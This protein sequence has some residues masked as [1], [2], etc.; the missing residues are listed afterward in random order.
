MRGAVQPF[1]KSAAR[2]DCAAG[3]GNGL[4]AGHRLVKPAPVEERPDGSDKLGVRREE[5]VVHRAVDDA[6][7]VLDVALW[8]WEPIVPVAAVGTTV[9]ATLVGVILLLRGRTE[10]SW[11]NALAA[12]LALMAAAFGMAL[13]SH[14]AGDAVL[15]TVL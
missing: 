4:P 11:G 6:V 9:A 2:E 1:A 13:L 12:S 15:D 7:P 10:E 5:V 8:D 3:A 14:L